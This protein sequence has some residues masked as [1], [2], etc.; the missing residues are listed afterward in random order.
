MSENARV[1]VALC[2]EDLARKF[3]A[4]DLKMGAVHRCCHERGGRFGVLA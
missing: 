1:A 4:G 3:V 2:G